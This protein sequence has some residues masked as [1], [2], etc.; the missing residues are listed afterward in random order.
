MKAC[1]IPAL[2]ESMVVMMHECSPGELLLMAAFMHHEDQGHDALRH[3][4]VLKGLIS[5][6]TH[7]GEFRVHMSV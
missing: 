7:R 6:M 5:F 1:I 2:L 4:A 3:D